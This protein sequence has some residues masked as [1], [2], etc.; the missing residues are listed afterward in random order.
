M[1]VPTMLTMLEEDI[2]S[3]RILILGG[4]ACHRDLSLLVH[5]LYPSISRDALVRL[6]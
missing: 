2:P 5:F 6:Q 1:Q 4:E 3:M